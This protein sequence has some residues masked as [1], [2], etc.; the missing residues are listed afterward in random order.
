MEKCTL[1]SKYI[2]HPSIACHR[3][4]PRKKEKCGEISPKCGWVGCLI[5]K[6]GPNPSYHPENRLFDPNFTFHHPKSHRNPGV[7]KQIRERSPKKSFFLG[8]GAPY[9]FILMTI[10]YLKHSIQNGVIL[11]ISKYYNFLMI[12]P[13]ILRNQHKSKH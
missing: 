10:L 11:D 8:G 6:Q 7:G 1:I 3:G 9:S 12:Q 2:C 5:L 13:F 4:A